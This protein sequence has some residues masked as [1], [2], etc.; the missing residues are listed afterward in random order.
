[1]RC[2]ICLHENHIVGCPHYVGKHLSHCEVCG[3]FIY[4]EEECLE[5]DDNELVH[6]DCVQGMRWLI[7]WL[8][9]EVKEFEG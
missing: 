4:E 2:K 5:N 7:N 8:G 6:L 3:E 1:M 9:Y